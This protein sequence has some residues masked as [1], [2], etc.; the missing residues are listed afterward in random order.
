MCTSENFTKKICP[1]I[2]NH[3]GIINLANCFI[4][5]VAMIK[6]IRNRQKVQPLKMIPWTTS[7]SYSRVKIQNSNYY[8]IPISAST[9]TFL[10]FA[11]VMIN[12]FSIGKKYV[13]EK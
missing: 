12:M 2:N 10:K 1:L 3:I 5:D 13:L 4:C 11:F 6:L 7:S 8:T 9:L